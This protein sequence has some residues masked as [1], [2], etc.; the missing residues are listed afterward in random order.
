MTEQ[1]EVIT[2][3]IPGTS[4][5]TFTAVGPDP[6]DAEASAAFVFLAARTDELLHEEMI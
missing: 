1:P 3:T 5:W 4:G 6:E 2:F